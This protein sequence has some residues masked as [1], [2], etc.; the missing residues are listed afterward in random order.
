MDPFTI[1]MLAGAGMGLL[2]GKRNEEK[3]A[4]NDK[5]RKAA[6]TY[7]PWTGMGD[8]GSQQLPGTLESGLGGAATGAMIGSMGAKG[9]AEK[10]ALDLGA[11]EM[12]PAALE[13]PIKDPS[14]GPLDFSSGANQ[15][16]MVAGMGP[17][18]AMGAQGSAGTL[19][20][21]GQMQDPNNPLLKYMQMKA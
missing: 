5:F 14:T 19:G 17:Y 9:G 21:M 18:S 1:A 12:A 15:G 7:S 3:M 4:D 16:T 13:T 6:I 11:G 8:P 10:P 20:G 2:K